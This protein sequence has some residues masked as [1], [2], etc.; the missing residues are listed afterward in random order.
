MAPLLT[1]TKEVE[2]GGRAGLQECGGTQ[3][4]SLFNICR[5]R[6][7]IFLSVVVVVLLGFQCIS[8]A[9]LC[10]RDSFH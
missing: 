1:Q 5:L 3:S 10:Q 9:F 6:T 8:A 2:R 7:E 4:I